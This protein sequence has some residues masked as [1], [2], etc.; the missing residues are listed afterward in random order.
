MINLIRQQ[1]LESWVLIAGLLLG[2]GS[3]AGCGGEEPPPPAPKKRVR[4]APKPPPPAVTSIEELMAQ[5]GIDERVYLEEDQAPG[6]DEARVGLLT[7]FDG[8]ASGR[9]EGIAP[10][11]KPME[12]DELAR[13]V[14][15]GALA[16]MA[17][18]I[19][20]I[21][22]LSGTTPDGQRAYLAMYWLPDH[23]GAQM[24]IVDDSMGALQFEAAPSVP[25]IVDYLGDDPFEEWFAVVADEQQQLTEPDLGLMAIKASRMM[26]AAEED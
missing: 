8:F 16:Q 15:S 17:S 21:E 2:M 4:E 3:V 11:L 22:I 6:T 20:E 1:R 13:M 5:H 23:M 26:E 10:R 9:P 14:E 12:R 7:F 18:M 24:W 25:G 19:E